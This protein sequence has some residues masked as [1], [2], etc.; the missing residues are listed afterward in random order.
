VS[1]HLGR[2][3]AAHL[4]EKQPDNL[5]TIT[6]FG[7]LMTHA[8]FVMDFFSANVDY[9]QN[10]DISP[11]PEELVCIHDM[12]KAEYSK[13]TLV[14]IALIEETSKEAEEFIDVISG[15]VMRNIVDIDCGKVDAGIR[16]RKIY[17]EGSVLPEE[18]TSR[19]GNNLEV[20]TLKGINFS[21]KI[22]EKLSGLALP[23]KTGKIDYE[24][25]LIGY[26]PSFRKWLGLI[27]EYYWERAE[28]VEA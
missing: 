28:P 8:V 12:A 5:Y 7:M 23:A 10:H 20:R 11:L 16:I 25:V 6:P 13:G 17:P 26:D 15:E 24:S 1:R 19:L 22:S 4:V 9:F 18:Y 3:T 2:L 21:M 27:F 14:N